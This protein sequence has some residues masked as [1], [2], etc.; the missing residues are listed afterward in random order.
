MKLLLISLFFFCILSDVYK[1]VETILSFG[2]RSVMT[3]GH[4]K[5][6]NY[7]KSILEKNNFK[8]TFD[9]FQQNTIIG[10]VTFTN[11]IA[12]YSKI[13][14]SKKIILACHFESK[15]FQNFE[16]LGATDA[17]LPCSFLLEFSKYIHDQ[18]ISGKW[19][20]TMKNFEFLFFDG[21]ESFKE[22]SER[23]SLYGSRY[24]ANKWNQENKLKDID[25]FILFDILG[26]SNP[27]FF[28]YHLHDVTKTHS[29]YLKLHSIEKELN[30]SNFFHANLLPWDL[31]DDHIPFGRFKVPV[32][33][34][35][36]NPFSNQ[37]HT[38][39]DTIHYL[40]RT[41]IYKLEKIFKKFID[42]LKDD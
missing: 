20:S 13:Y 4:F 7:I 5:T 40:N 39:E 29:K 14:S 37:W 24:L 34:I 23:D 26:H 28:S 9:S 11:I 42:F 30:I 17:A 32:L 41:T 12:P 2:P 1:H 8:V 3:E 36:S 35:I 16:F 10:N 21:E 6:R 25:T 15:N 19:N 31:D 18:I 22:W 27:S 38:K 33:H